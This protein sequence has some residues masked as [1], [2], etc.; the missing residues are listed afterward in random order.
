MGVFIATR[1][2]SSS[3]GSCGFCSAEVYACRIRLQRSSYH[4]RI[5]SVFHKIAHTRIM[6]QVGIYKFRRLFSGCANILRKQNRLYRILCRNLLPC[7]MSDITCYIANRHTVHP[8][9]GLSM[10]ILS[11]YKCKAHVFIA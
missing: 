6:R 11:I 3:Y 9:C 1:L 7:L 5:F 10:Y 4:S 8:R 2:Q